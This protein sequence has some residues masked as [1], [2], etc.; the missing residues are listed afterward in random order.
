MNCDFVEVNAAKLF[1]TTLYCPSFSRRKKNDINSTLD[2]GYSI[3]FAN[4][5]RELINKGLILELGIHH[6]NS[7]NSFNLVYDLVEPFRIF[8]DAMVYSNKDS[9]FDSEYIELLVDIIDKRG[10]YKNKIYCISD[11]IE[12]Y[13]NDCIK[14]LNEESDDIGEVCICSQL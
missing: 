10:I 8:V 9:V 7:T 14:Y 3:L 2:Y 12:M 5:S 6:K 11:I 1:F 4:I 13:V